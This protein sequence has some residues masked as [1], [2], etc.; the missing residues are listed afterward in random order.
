[1]C[2]NN[3]SRS[4]DIFS[5]IKLGERNR[6]LQLMCKEDIGDFDEAMVDHLLGCPGIVAL[7]EKRIF[8]DYF[9]Q[10]EPS[11]AIG[12]THGQSGPTEGS[13]L[14]SPHQWFPDPAQ[15]EARAFE[16]GEAAFKAAIESNSG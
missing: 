13:H 2:V 5:V 8:P 14:I 7:I 16:A 11:P 9:P 12:N 6:E 1:M 15:V 4:F 10:S 3:N